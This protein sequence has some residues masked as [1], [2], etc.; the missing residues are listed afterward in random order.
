LSLG[1]APEQR[2]DTLCVYETPEGVDLTLS[3]AGPPA[4][5]AALAIDALI[6]GAL[7]LVLV[8]LTALSGLGLGLLFLGVFLIEWFYPV[9]FE[10]RSGATPGKRAM[11]LAVIAE[12]G[13]PVTPAAS[14]IRNLLRVVDFL[15]VAYGAGLI[16]TLVDPRFRRLGDLAAGTLV[17]HV[18]PAGAGRDIPAREPI[19]PPSA[20][21]H[22]LQQAILDY[23]ERAQRLSP[24]RREEL[25]A[26]LGRLAERQGVGTEAT[27]L[28]YA[29]WLVRGR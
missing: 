13:T 9:Y 23:A 15:P 11:G 24:Q 4:R 10:L 27:L 16:C 22:E 5:A 21:P 19:V 12:D 25:A 8:P 3:A 18:P 7:Y 1:P 28:G 29:N 2:T 6:K 20:L 14:L 26:A 17:V